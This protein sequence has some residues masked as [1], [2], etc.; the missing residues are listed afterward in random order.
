MSQTK[1]LLPPV[2]KYFKTN[3]HTHSTISDG[4]LPPEEVQA[5]YKERGYSILSLTDHNVVVDHSAL[6]DEDFLMLTG[7]EYNVND[8]SLPISHHKTYHLNFIA[9]KPD[10]LWQPF[11]PATEREDVKALLAKTE[12]EAMPRVYDIDAVNA[13]I[14]KANEKGHLVIYNHPVW[15]LQDYTDYAGLKGV[16]GLEI[17]NYGSIRAGFVDDHNG[18]IL[19]D[20]MNL[21]GSIMP[22]CADDA[23]GTSSMCGAWNMIGAEELTYDSVIEAMEKGNLYA[24]TGPEIYELSITGN[25]LK[26]RCSDARNIWVECGNRY[27]RAAHPVHNDG[28]V[29]EAE[30]DLSFWMGR[31][32]G[33]SMDWLRVIVNGPYGHYA[34][35]RPYTYAELT[36]AE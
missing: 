30:F 8:D 24:S 17:C 9:K 36:A 14:A 26:V 6:N 10:I 35:T 3:L 22:V 13:M 28:L 5:Y 23:H 20:M 12:N 18:L 15:S 1:Y 32:N 21:T 25:I 19:R 4:R 2:K 7:A 29:R 31:C 16:W 33:S 34:T 11:H 27:G